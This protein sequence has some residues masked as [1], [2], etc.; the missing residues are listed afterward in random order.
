[1]PMR[2]AVDTSTMVFVFFPNNWS[3]RLLVVFTVA[4]PSD[5]RG[6]Q[7]AGPIAGYQ[8]RDQPS[9]AANN[10]LSPHTLSQAW[11]TLLLADPTLPV[12]WQL[13]TKERRSLLR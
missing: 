9:V 7:S 10:N 12:S 2:G 6:L 5:A 8:M 13:D 11:R 1:P 4:T 3:R